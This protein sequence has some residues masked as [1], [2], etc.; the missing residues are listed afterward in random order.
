MTLAALGAATEGAIFSGQRV[1]ADAIMLGRG[2]ALD[3]RTPGGFGFIAVL[4]DAAL[5]PPDRRHRCA[6][7]ARC[8]ADRMVRGAARG[9]RRIGAAVR[10]GPQ[11]ADGCGVRRD[12]RDGAGPSADAAAR[13][14][15]WH[16]GQFSQDDRRHFGKPPSQT[17]RTAA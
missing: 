3:L 2:D 10:A 5:Q 4:V 17:R 6:P 7:V 9:R 14:G 16:P 12:L 11:A 1:P 15:L 8:P 13:W